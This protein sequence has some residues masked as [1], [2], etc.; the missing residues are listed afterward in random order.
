[1]NILLDTCAISELRKPEP[2][3]LFLAWFESCDE[4]LLFLSSVTESGEKLKAEIRK[5]EM[6]K[7]RKTR[8]ARKGGDE[9]ERKT[10]SCHATGRSAC[11]GKL[12]NLRL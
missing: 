6:G 11:G 7:P 10:E 5:A 12:G 1:M 8:K 9:D 3:P 2:S 4:R